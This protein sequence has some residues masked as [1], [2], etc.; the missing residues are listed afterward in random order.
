MKQLLLF[1]TLLVSLSLIAQEEDIVWKEASKESQAYHKYRQHLS[2]PPYNLEKLNMVIKKQ[3]VSDDEDN[4]VLK[5]KAYSALSLKEKFTYNMLH[6][7]SFSQNCDAMPPIQ[8]EQKKIFGY[9]PDAFDEFAWSE[10]QEL[11]LTEN[12]DSVMILI[13][14]CASKNNRLGINFKQ[15]ILVMNATEMIPFLIKVYNVQHKDHDILSLLMLLMKENKYEPFLASA[16]F[17]KLYGDDSNY[18][19][20]I[21]YNKPNEDL[22]IK[23]A[24]DFANG[25]RN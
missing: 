19:D 23:R 12:R 24:T 17:R 15:A 21:T 5:D 22:I 14:E 16:S 1:T 3:V 8:D 9:L 25:S 2:Y 20:Y 7:E 18:M 4:L 6:G 10:R 11:F 13:K